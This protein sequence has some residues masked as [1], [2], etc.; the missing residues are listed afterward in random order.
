MPWFSTKGQVLQ[1]LGQVVA[2]C[3]GMHVAFPDMVMNNLLSAG[4]ILF[5]LLVM[6]VLVSMW[7]LI[8]SIKRAP[9]RESMVVNEVESRGW[10]RWL[11]SLLYGVG[12]A[13]GLY[14]LFFFAGLPGHFIR[15]PN[16][17][18]P[19]SVIGQLLRIRKFCWM[20]TPMITVR[21]RM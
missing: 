16:L 21:L 12:T 7:V 14:I 2:L 4:A 8:S 17:Y 3:I 5:Y 11:A 19:I 9:S 6:T 18:R 15:W 10:K 13:V 20:G 1:L